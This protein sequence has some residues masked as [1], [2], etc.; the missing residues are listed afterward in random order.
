M[1]SL[2]SMHSVNLFYYYYYYVHKQ[3]TCQGRVSKQTDTPRRLGRCLTWKAYSL[4]KEIQTDGL[5]VLFPKGLLS[6]P[7]GEWCLKQRQRGREWSSKSSSALI[8]RTENITL[9]PKTESRPK[10]GTCEIFWRVKHQHFNFFPSCF[11]RYPT[12]SRAEHKGGGEGGS[13]CDYNMT[14]W[15]PHLTNRNAFWSW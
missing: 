9:E 3:H 12:K 14:K 2:Q 8:N 15:Y 11:S 1:Y 4:Q 5:F 10:N 6:K 7:G 13:L